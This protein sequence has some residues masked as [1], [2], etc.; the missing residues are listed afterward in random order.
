MHRFACF[1]LSATAFLIFLCAPASAQG[2]SAAS[3]AG[4]VT[5][6]TGAVLPGVTVEAAS[7]S[8]IERL[9]TAVTNEQGLYRIIEL[10]PGSYVVTFA[11]TGFATVKREGIELPP[12][13][14]ATVNAELKVGALEET[15]TVSGQSPLV[16]TQNVTRQ[17][18]IP[19]LLLD[20]VPTGKNLLSFY[21]L[22]PAAV[23]PTN[24]QDVG[25]S[26]G[27]TTA[28]ASVHGTKQGETKMMLDGMSFNWFAGEGSGRTF[29]VNALTAQEV[30]VDV[31]SGSSAEYTA[32]GVVVNLVPKDG[33]NRFGGTFFA[34][35]SDHNLQS[36]NLTNALRALGT[37]TTSGTQSVYDLN[38]VITGPIV[39]NRLWFMS[40]HRR[41]GRRERI[42][43]LFHDA[44]V[45][46]RVTGAPASVWKFVP[47]YNQPGEPAEDFHSDNLRL[48]WQADAKNKIN[49]MYEWQHNNVPN[50]F[51][52]LNAGIMSME[53][54]SPYCYRNEL[55]MGTWTNPATNKLLFEG[56]WL[57]LNTSNNTFEHACAGIPTNRLIR[58]TTLSFPY[59]G[60][61][62]SQSESGQRPFKQ[63]FSV[64]YITGGHRFKVGMAADESLPRNT[65]TTRGDTPFTYTFKNGVPSSVT[66]YASPVIGGEVKIRPDLGIFV[67]DQWTARRLTLNLG[68]RYEYHRSYAAAITTPAGPL[69]DSHSLPA[70][71]CIPC[72]HDINPR[73]GV[74]YDLFGDSKT[75]LKASL[76]RYVALA[77]NVLSSTFSPQNAIVASTTRSW[78]DNDHDFFPDCNLRD[79]EMNGEC[80]PMQNKSFGQTQIRTR[81]DPNWISGWG[82]RGY[83]W[84][85]SVSIDRQLMPGVAMNAGYYR[86]WYG[87]FTVTHNELTSPSDYDPY[88]I[89]APVDS[90]LPSSISGQQI[91]GFYDIKPEKFGLIDNVVTLADKYGKATEYYNGA[92]VNVVARL[93]RGVNLAG[94]W[95]VGNA[96]SSLTTFPG[97]TTSKASQCF[98]VNSPQDLYNC[99]TGNPY[100][101]RIKLNGSVPLPW[102]FQ[103]AAVYQN[104]PG[105]NYAALYTATTAQVAET[106]HRNLAGNASSVTVDLLQPLSHFLNDRINQLDVRLTRIFRT[107]RGRF[108]VNFDIY[109]VLNTST[110]LWPNNTYG[111]GSAWLRPTSTMD[112]RLLKFGAQFDF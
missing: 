88:C 93:P 21:A 41:W 27:E 36:D 54:G 99:K 38:A 42:A 19:K 91:C 6:A 63:R 90:R 46:L 98:I 60:N 17:T 15:V 33:G 86:T 71:D 34:T 52:Y 12:N 89:T 47:D 65:Y 85:A 83:N 103:A 1:G 110:V 62:P 22:T 55:V 68:L 3:I 20:T 11:L 49:V 78:T 64:S 111:D 75:A 106:L 70:L 87:N 7:P 66:E 4:V 74:A 30:I 32:S 25:G 104:L 96:V 109:N 94:G 2:T 58:D 45:G 24:A 108:Q 97:A 48:T 44:N 100:Q 37:V 101:H 84:T 35:G 80:G 13:F 5:D 56:G 69:V 16:D 77:S 31:A 79:P 59:N 9:R 102:N 81:P 40:A 10:K 105:P 29:Y 8:L 73:F 18:V 39:S 26:K 72:W 53:A 95:N 28:R 107:P 82:K 61:G 112:A 67:Q 76:G 23:T 57:F 14:T 51:S 43:N 50:N 92:D